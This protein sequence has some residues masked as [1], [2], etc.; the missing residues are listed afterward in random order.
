[1]SLKILTNLRHGKLH[2]KF[3]Q[4]LEILSVNLRADT[5]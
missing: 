3:H 4:G 1:M 2:M 5:I